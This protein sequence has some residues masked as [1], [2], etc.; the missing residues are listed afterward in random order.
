V[1]EAEA[2]AR[3]VRRLSLNRQ[4]TEA[5]VWLEKG[6]LYLRQDGHARFAQGEGAE[7]LSGFVLGRGGV[8]LAFRD[9]SRLRLFFRLGRL[10]KLHF[11]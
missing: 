10:R 9:G 1:S 2:W 3:R 4:G 7:G 11:S 8:E 5:Q 6:F